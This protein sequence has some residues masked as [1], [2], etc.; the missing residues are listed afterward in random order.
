MSVFVVPELAT[1]PILA[2]AVDRLEPSIV[3]HGK[4]A[5]LPSIVVKDS[6]LSLELGRITPPTENVIYLPDTL[7]QSLNVPVPESANDVTIHG[8]EPPVAPAAKP[9]IGE[10]FTKV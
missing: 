7:K 3:I 9:S 8:V 1:M 6:I 2:V 5:E 10:A 4:G